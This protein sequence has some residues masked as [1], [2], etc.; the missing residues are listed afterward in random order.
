MKSMNVNLMKD[1][2]SYQLVKTRVLCPY[3]GRKDDLRERKLMLGKQEVDGMEKLK[4]ENEAVG[5]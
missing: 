2:Q 5:W 4:F 1:T 3:K